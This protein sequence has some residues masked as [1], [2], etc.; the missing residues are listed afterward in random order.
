MHPFLRGDHADAEFMPRH[1]SD[2]PQCKACGNYATV[3]SLIHRNAKCNAKLVAQ[4]QK[5]ELKAVKKDGQL[6]DKWRVKVFGAKTLDDIA[7]LFKDNS[8][9]RNCYIGSYRANNGFAQKTDFGQY[10]VPLCRINRTIHE[11][12]L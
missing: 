9:P 8:F 4:P 2:S 6:R 3:I 12:V 11:H 7:A 1:K 10:T 5:A